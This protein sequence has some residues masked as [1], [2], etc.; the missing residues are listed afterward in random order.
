MARCRPAIGGGKIVALLIGG[1]SR[2]HRYTDADWDALIDGMNRLGRQG[3]RWLVST[4]RRTPVAVEARLRQGMNSDYLTRAVWWHEAPERVMRDFLGAAD[5]VMVTQDSLTM[6]CEAVAAGKPAVA[7]A[8]RQTRSSRFIETILDAQE[9]QRRIR[10]LP[11]AGLGTAS[12]HA[13]DFSPVEQAPQREYAATTLRILGLAKMQDTQWPDFGIIVP[14]Y[15]RPQYLIEA[16][17]SVLAQTYPQ[18]K[19]FI[20]NDG[21]TEDYSEVMPWLQDSRIVML[22]AGSNGGCNRARNLAIDAAMAAGVDY[23]TLLDDEE[24]LDPACLEVALQKIEAHPEVGWFISNNSG[25]RKSSTR[26]IVEERC[27]DWIDDYV[28]GKALRGDKTHVIAAR[29]LREIRFDGRFRA[30]NM[31]PFFLRLAARTHIWG[32]TYPSKVMRYLD[33]GITKS[34][35]RYP[36]TW[37]EIWSRFARHAF[38]IRL[39][40]AKFKAY[41]GLLMEFFKTPRR[42]WHVCGIGLRRAFRGFAETRTRSG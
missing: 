33:G 23:I 15:N 13:G 35:S 11:I 14:T 18:W 6:L 40:P 34:N 16:I 21:S 27:Y 1:D 24:R 42:I 26:D 32:Y 36:R 12:V 22:H 20:C 37:L 28:Y 31:W 25:E 29:V 8:P 30:S 5:A 38:A 10:R 9:R 2:S 39:R 17:S 7:L 19:L 3:W 4:S 41:R